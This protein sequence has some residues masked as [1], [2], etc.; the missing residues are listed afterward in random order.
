MQVVIGFLQSGVSP[1][2]VRETFE[3]VSFLEAA[4]WSREHAGQVTRLE[5]Y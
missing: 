3:I 5:R 4:N 2:D 1:I